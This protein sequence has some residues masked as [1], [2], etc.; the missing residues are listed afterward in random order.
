VWSGGTPEKCGGADLTGDGNVD[1]ADLYV[2]TNYWL[3]SNCAA[4]DDCG[5]A[6][7]EPVGQPDGDV[8]MKDLAIFAR[9][10]LETG[11]AP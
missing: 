10:W 2:V 5:G 1:W 7:L 3:E 9:H 4:F 8:D 6:D 11:C